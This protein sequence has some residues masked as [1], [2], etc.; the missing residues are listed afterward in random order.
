MPGVVVHSVY[1]PPNEKFD[2]PAIGHG[3]LRHIVIGDFNSHMSIPQHTTTEKRMNSG[4]IHATDTLI[5]NAKH[6]TVQV[7]REATTPNSYLYLKALLTCV[8]KNHCAY[9]AHSTPPDLCTCK[10]S[11]CGTSNTIQKAFHYTES[12]QE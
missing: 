7:G 5:H 2:L 8:K 12:R 11:N 4:Q 10:P 9:P 6:S 3:N 1:R